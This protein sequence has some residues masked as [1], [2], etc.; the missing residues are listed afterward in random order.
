MAHRIPTLKKRNHQ[1]VEFAE[2][3]N[4][5]IFYFAVATTG[6]RQDANSICEIAVMGPHEESPWSTTI[7]PSGQFT[8]QA[9]SYNG[10]TSI[11]TNGERHLLMNGIKVE[12]SPLKQ[13]LDDFIKYLLQRADGSHIVVL[14]G[15]NSQAF[16][17]KLLLQAF[18]QC[19]L[20]ES[21]K[22]LEDAGICYGDPF[23]M[24]QAMRENFPQLP[25]ELSLKLPDVYN[26]LHRH[27]DSESDCK[28]FNASHIVQML[29]V[30]MSSLDVSKTHLKAAQCIYTLTSAK[31]VLNYNLRVKRYQESMKDRLYLPGGSRSTISESMAKK[32]AQS[33][34][35]YRDLKKTYRTRGREGLEKLLKASKDGER[36][37]KPRVT[38]D[39]RVIS[40]IVSHFEQTKQNTMS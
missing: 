1:L 24:I 22:T 2:N 9:S 29:K 18:K 15:W 30:V 10:Y 4:I 26:H 11:D 23:L 19:G 12:T 16:H 8:S 7:L 25:G 17:I 34:L 14:L 40:K 33:G 13:G 35:K 20:Q 5:K 31:R 36:Q 37:G 39:Q 28:K 38:R 6:L 27:D 32:I 3:T 21:I